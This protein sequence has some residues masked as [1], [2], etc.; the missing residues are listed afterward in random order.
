[1]RAYAGFEPHT[2]SFMIM[3]RGVGDPNYGTKTKNF[4]FLSSIWNTIY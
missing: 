1:M 3:T 4:H 2:I